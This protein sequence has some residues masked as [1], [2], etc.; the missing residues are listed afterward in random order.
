MLRPWPALRRGQ[1]AE[2]VACRTFPDADRHLV[3]TRD[4]TDARW[5]EGDAALAMMKPMLD[6]MRI[7]AYV[8]VNGEIT[9]SD[10]SH[11]AK[12]AQ[13]GKKQMITLVDM[14][15]GKLVTDPEKL[16]KLSALENEKDIRKVAEALNELPEITYELKEKITVDFK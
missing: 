7:R 8:K 13:T 2:P 1:S 15:L 4:S 3:V 9:K 12:S 14:Q 10:A 11:V 16:K 6:G 5:R